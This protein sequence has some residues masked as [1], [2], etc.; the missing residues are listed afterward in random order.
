VK[1]EFAEYLITSLK[2]EIPVPPETCPTIN[3]AIASAQ[4][5][6]R[7]CANLPND[8]SITVKGFADVVALQLV[9]METWLEG[10]REAN[11]TLRELGK[12][13]H[14]LAKDL[15]SQFPKEE[16]TR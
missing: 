14:A 2:K 3:K 6:L 13:W 7:T 10:L 15:A 9:N 16:T 11:N 4:A 12:E 1:R 5:I 8:E